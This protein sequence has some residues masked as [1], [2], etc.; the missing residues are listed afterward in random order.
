MK[1]RPLESLAVRTTRKGLACLLVLALVL[2]GAMPA[3]AQGAGGG[4]GPGSSQK[5]SLNPFLTVTQAGD[6]A[7]AGIGMRGTGSG[8]ITIAS[9]PP[10]ATVTQAFLYWA[11]VATTFSPP[12]ANGVFNGTPITG[13]STGTD[14]DPCWPGTTTTF[15]FRANVTALVLPGGNGVYT[16]TGFATGPPT[17]TTIF[18]EATTPPL[19][20]GATL[21]ILYTDPAALENR[22]IVI[23]DGADTIDYAPVGSV[24]TTMSIPPI[25]VPGNA[26]TTYIVADGQPHP[27]FG[28]QT[29]FNSNVIATDPPGSFNGSDGK[30]WDT[31]SYNVSALVSVGDTSVTAGLV[32]LGDCLVHIS[33]VFSASSS[34]VLPFRLTLSPAAAVNTVDSKHTVT[35]TVTGAFGQPAPGVTVIFQVTGSVNTSGSCVTNASGQCSFTYT[36]PALPGADAIHAFADTNGNGTQDPGEPF[37]DA[38]KT[39]VLPTS[40]AFCQVD[41]T[42]GGWIHANNGDRANFGGN[43]KVDSQNNPQGQ[44]EYQDKGPAQPMN[45]HSIDVLAVICTTSPPPAQASIFGTATIDGS[46]SFDYRIDVKDVAEPGKGADT[47]RIR[48]STVPPYDSGEHTLEGGNIQIHK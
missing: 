22:D 23:Y 16:L 27:G 1:G 36:G 29:V 40:T 15:A 5:N 46:G 12:F 35:A 26:T 8:T 13:T 37:G 41:I 17:P 33:Q 11:T 34:K 10:G 48:L 25:G 6:Y 38:T 2:S 14:G 45:V 21:V 9:I 19:A 3:A 7:A 20:E 28:D 31:D 24:S 30:I 32:G 42:Y 44:E 43:A 4:S 39:W 18:G 47:Y